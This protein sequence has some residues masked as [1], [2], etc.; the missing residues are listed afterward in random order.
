[1]NLAACR[2]AAAADLAKR[3]GA[4]MAL[5]R[6]VGI[7]PEIDRLMSVQAGA[8]LIETMTT[9]ARTELEAL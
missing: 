8:D 2:A 5:L 4:R 9:C 7:P 1:M 6:A 3:A